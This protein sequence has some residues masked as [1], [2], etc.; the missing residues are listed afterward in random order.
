MKVI[1]ASRYTDSC[2]LKLIWIV[3]TKLLDCKPNDAGKK[4]QE[5]LLRSRGLYE[6]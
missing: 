6:C 4:V 1:L 2:Y 5:E 3:L